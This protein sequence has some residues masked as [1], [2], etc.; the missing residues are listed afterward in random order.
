MAETVIP[1]KKGKLSLLSRRSMVVNMTLSKS[2]IS[3]EYNSEFTI[4]ELTYV[5]GAKLAINRQ[6]FIVCI[7]LNEYDTFREFHYSCESIAESTGWVDSIIQYTYSNI[8]CIKRIA[9]LVNPISGGKAGR[10]HFDYLFLPLVQYTPH[11]FTY[12]GSL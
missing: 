2:T 10:R 9:V 7:Y 1:E 8:D 6:D 11:S 12:I 3:W 4:F 5:L